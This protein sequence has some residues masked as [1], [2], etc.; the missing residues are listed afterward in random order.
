MP[1]GIDATG[2]LV[3]VSVTGAGDAPP[4]SEP[5]LSRAAT[6]RLVFRIV[7][8]YI[9]ERFRRLNQVFGGRVSTSVAWVAFSS[10]LESST[11]ALSISMGVP[12]ETLRRQRLQLSSAGLLDGGVGCSEEERRQALAAEKLSAVRGIIS[13][14]RELERIGFDTDGFAG[15]PAAELPAS[16]CSSQVALDATIKAADEL[17]LRAIEVAIPIHGSLAPALVYVGVL[18]ANADPITRDPELA[19]RYRS[20]DTPPPDDVRQAVSAAEVA[21]RVGLPL[22]TARRHLENMVRLGRCQKIGSRYLLS[23]DFMQ[24]PEVLSTGL[25][26]VGKFAACV[27]TIHRVGAPALEG[28]IIARE[29]ASLDASRRLRQ[30]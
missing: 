6:Q 24:R 11:H 3:V 15:L 12:I 18:T 9:V 26:V 22:S 10:N 7:C 8:E 4:R 14:A 29:L 2:Q 21:R 17:L 20:A 13:M 5:D 28:A 23:M 27:R 1:G 16:S 30:A 25:S 19:W